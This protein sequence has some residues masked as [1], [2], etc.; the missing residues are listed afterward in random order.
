MTH[1][2]LQAQIEIIREGKSNNKRS[3]CVCCGAG[4]ISSGSEELL[5]KLK[6]EISIAGMDKELELIPTGCMGPCNQG[7]LVK[8]LPD[9][10]IYQKVNT[11]N[12]QGLTSTPY[13]GRKA[14]RG[15]AHLF[16]AR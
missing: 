10:T 14:R 8:I 11:Q 7:P 13:R 12:V 6:E 9:H 4:C 1:Q 2:E 5:K 15:H 16:R 3:V